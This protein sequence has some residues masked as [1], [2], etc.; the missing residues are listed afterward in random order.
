MAND[1]KSATASFAKGDPL[2]K[3]GEPVK[4]IYLVQS[5]LVSLSV[6]TPTGKVEVSQVTPPQVVGIEALHGSETYETSAFAMNDTTAV[7]LPVGAVAQSL[8]QCA[9]TLK[10]ILTGLINSNT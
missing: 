6:T 9:P 4:Y 2:Y 1:K 8:N 3:H 5:G 10:L 7:E